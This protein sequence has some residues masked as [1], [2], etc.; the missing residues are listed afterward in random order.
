MSLIVQT[1]TAANLAAS[2]GGTAG[3]NGT[4]TAAS[5]PAT[6]FAQTLVQS[7]GGTAAAAPASG[8]PV[9]G[10]NLVALLQGLLSAGQ[11]KT[12]ETDHPDVQTLAL[13]EGIKQ[14]VE[15]LDSSLEADPALLAA[16]QGWL[17]QV[18][19]L[20]SGSHAAAQKDGAE[21]AAET[22]VTLSPLASNPETLRFAVQDELN[23]LVQLVQTAAA[24]GNQDVAVKGAALLGQF[25]A[26][27]AAS[28]P[29]DQKAKPLTTNTAE[30]AAV[31]PEQVSAAEARPEVHNRGDLAVAV[32]KLLDASVKSD[33]QPAATAQNAQTAAVTAEADQGAEAVTT[34]LA[35]AVKAGESAE[36]TVPAGKSA[37][38]EEPKIVTAGHLSLRDGMTAPLKSEAA[39]V[40]V[41]QFAREMNSF[42]GG[43]L[44]IV[45]KGGVAEAT[46]TL[47]PENLGQVDV[48]ITMHNGNLVAQFLTQHA[49]TKD[50]LEQQMS[51]L[52]LALQSQ[53]LQVERLEVS[54]NSSSPQSQWTGQQG[55]QAGAGGQQQGRRSRERQ[56]ESD[57]AVLAAELGGEWKD[58]V[59]TQQELA[60]D[61]G[62]SAKA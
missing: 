60:Q 28:V 37:G 36:D 38:A 10:S 26:M 54:Q 35:A 62:F 7:M 8:T 14:D 18:S 42:I 61:G 49:G 1:L 21:P 17:L 40:P 59:A 23:S 4:G 11:V 32:R 50:L 29:A 31:S 48:K 57:D 12:E 19:A 3:T 5:S 58:W 47:F 33:S 41:Q 6:P 55:Q 15:K 53:G 45:R 2:A 44:E 46:I 52:R 39:P 56:E 13:L 20:L 43:K 30:A 24:N 51:Q 25:S 16:L 27:L 34:G 22:A 9:A